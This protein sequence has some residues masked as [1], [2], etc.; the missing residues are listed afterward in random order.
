[1]GIRNHSDDGIP[2]GIPIP[3][4]I[5]IPILCPLSSVLCSLLN[6]DDGGRTLCPD[7]MRLAAAL[8]TF[9]VAGCAHG[10]TTRSGAAVGAVSAK[11]STANAAAAWLCRPDLPADA[12][13]SADLTATELR[14]DGSRVVVAHHAAEH[15]RVDCFYVYPTVDLELVPG[16]HTDFADVRKMRATTLAQAARFSE[17]CALWVPLYRQITLGT[18]LQPTEMLER[19]LAVAFADVERA[20]AEYLAQADR[21]RKVVLI[22]HSQG[23]E[24]VI[25]LLR[26]FFD[27]DPAMRARLLLAMP[28]GGDVDVA[29][30]S[31]RGGTTK[32]IPACSRPNEAGCIVAYRTYAAGER[33]DP[34]RWAPPPGRETVCVD[35]AAID[36]GSAREPHPLSR[37]YFAVWPELRG[38]MRGI[39]DVTTPFVLLRDF[40]TARCVRGPGGYAWLEAAVTSS[41]SDAR[42]SPVDLRDRRFRIG[43][44]GLHVLDMQLAQG[45]LVDMV[46][47]RVAA[48]AP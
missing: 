35:P 28:I 1:M 37:T 2:A 34:D 5:P 27:D 11:S 33:V 23:A 10:P 16:N 42:T 39:D 22:G 7:P 14:S 18:Y 44:L 20:F 38:H 31:V 12:C 24:M 3:I 30:G 15:P 40:Y 48:L 21:T 47:R 26:R 41:T 25:R 45:D 9:F 8:I 32:N 43:K 4:P 13:R 36:R 19:G 29:G 6:L 46:A 17:T